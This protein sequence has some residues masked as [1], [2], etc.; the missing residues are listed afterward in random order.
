M[1]PLV[2]GED[3]SETR[4]SRERAAG[5]KRADLFVNPGRKGRTDTANL[6]PCRA[7]RCRSDGARR[8]PPLPGCA[9]ASPGVPLKRSRL[10]LP[11]GHPLVL[12]LLS[13]LISP[14]NLIANALACGVMAIGSSA[15][16][17]LCA[18][19]KERDGARGTRVQVN[20]SLTQFLGHDPGE[21]EKGDQFW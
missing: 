15:R 21:R 10:P 6:E 9:A 2:A 20:C 12:P 18:P 19:F 11:Q 13:K 1:T 17:H 16:H 8:P 14:P 4:K 5:W 7:G 3:S